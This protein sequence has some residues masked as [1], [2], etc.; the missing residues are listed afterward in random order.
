MEQF[1]LLTAPLA[2]SNLIE[3][4]AGTGK[5][6][7]IEGLFIRLVVEMELPI[8]QILVLTFTNAA[9]EELK[10][11]IRNKL[12]QARDAFAAGGQTDPLVESLVKTYPDRKAARDRLHDALIDFDQAAIYTI[13]GF[14]Q[15]IIHENAFETQSLFDTEL[16]SNQSG[17][18]QEVVD[19]FWRQTFYASEPEWIGFALSE[20][21]NPEYF[22]RLLDKVKIPEIKVLPEAAEPVRKALEPYRRAFSPPPSWP[23]RPKRT[24]A[25]PNTNFLNFATGSMA[26]GCS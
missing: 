19:D 10:I 5:T 21:K 22:V 1:N 25:P 26:R 7:N 23:K 4:S 13:H 9:T 11:R 17:L 2:G 24:S 14:C 8:D 3:A 16:V 12:V 18:L 6:Y 15:R 20:V